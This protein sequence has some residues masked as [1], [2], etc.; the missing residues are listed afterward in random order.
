MCRFFTRTHGKCALIQGRMAHQTAPPASQL[1]CTTDCFHLA[2][3]GSAELDPKLSAFR[4]KIDLLTQAAAFA[5][6]FD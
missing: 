5:S 3:R 2:K 1:P 4:P 6:N